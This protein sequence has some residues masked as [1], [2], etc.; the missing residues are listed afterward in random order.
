LSAEDIT[1]TANGTGAAKGT[2]TGKG[3][4]V[5][6]LAVSGIMAG[7]TVTVGVA[8]NGY[9]ITSAS[10]QVTVYVRS[11]ISMVLV[12]GGTVGTSHAWSSGGNYPRPVT[13]Q[14]FKISSTETTYE[15]WCEVREW[16]ESN[17][18]SFANSGYAYVGGS[19]Y[20]GA[21]T[22]GTKNQ[23]VVGVSWRDAVVWCNAYSE[24]TGKTAVYK[25]AGGVLRESESSSVYEG[26]GKAENAVIDALATGYRLPTEAE[27]EYAARGGVPGTS[28]PWTY[29]YAGSDTANDVAWTSENS[30]SGTPEVG[31]KLANS[32][33]LY[34]MSGNVWEWCWDLYSSD[35]SSRVLRGG[36]WRYDADYA[37]VSNRGSNFPS[38]SNDYDGFRVAC[39]PSSVE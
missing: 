5:Y 4:G 12:A 8:K 13:I 14:S 20:S 16:A 9:A 24:K 19:L 10:K 38:Y 28:V 1:L 39:P 17:G 7:G 29:T 2:L 34:D 33:G 26:S 30:G 27:W 15:Q 23:P 11:A 31:G 22:E 32:L 21:P 25:Y 36:S 3:S 18:Y 6:E 37:A 35:Y